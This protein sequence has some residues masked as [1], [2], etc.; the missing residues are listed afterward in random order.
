MN[1]RKD[2]VEKL[3]LTKAS[4]YKKVIPHLFKV[5]HDHE[6]KLAGGTR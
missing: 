2:V 1:F 6:N 4:E 5:T 3:S